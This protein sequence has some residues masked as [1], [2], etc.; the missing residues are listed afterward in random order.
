MPVISIIMPAYNAEQYIKDSIESVLKQPFP[1]WEL[2]IVNDGSVDNTEQ[3]VLTFQ[4][5]RIK[6]VKQ[7][8][9]G[10][11]S[12]RNKGLSMMQGDFFCF[13]DADDLMTPSGLT[14]RIHVF[15]LNPALSFVGGGQ[16]HYNSDLSKVL[17]FQLPNYEGFPKRGLIRLNEGCFI[18]C[19][20]WLIKRNRKRNYQFPEGW[21]HSED[22]GFFL[23]ISEDGKLGFTKEIVQVYR[24]L[25]ESAM[26]N[27]E[28]L[29]KGYRNYYSY[30]KSFN[31]VR[32]ADLVYLNFR[33]RRI[34]FLSCLRMGKIRNAFEFA[35][36]F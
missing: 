23:S 6:Y 21:T 35:F 16:V 12:A 5:T 7:Q 18:N 26:T 14:S 10:V 24:R 20:T 28:G 22:L 30:V 11:S 3:V 27:L 8:N 36:N 29:A 4:D 2:I 33:I 9:S 31:G 25:S 13:L 17:K 1:N 34:M 15:Q 19:G 32:K